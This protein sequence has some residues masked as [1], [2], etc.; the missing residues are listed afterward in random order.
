MPEP[1]FDPQADPERATK[2]TAHAVARVM[3]R[4]PFS[5]RISRHLEGKENK[6]GLFSDIAALLTE[7]ARRNPT[8]I[9]ERVQQ[10]GQEIETARQKR[11]QQQGVTP[12]ATE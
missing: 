12:D 8:V 5:R 3:D 11:A 9:R 1:E 7:L 10:F 4:I 6:A 2:L